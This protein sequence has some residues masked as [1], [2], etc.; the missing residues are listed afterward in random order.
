[1]ANHLI[2]HRL[3]LR[4]NYKFKFITNALCVQ[5]GAREPTQIQRIMFEYWPV[6]TGQLI[7]E[8]PL[9]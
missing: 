3:P 9:N 1:M 2:L 4:L 7:C 5:T 6:L 8:I